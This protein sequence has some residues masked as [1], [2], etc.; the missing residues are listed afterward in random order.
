[1]PVFNRSQLYVSAAFLAIVELAA[2]IMR[3]AH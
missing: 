3:A 1:V 2:A